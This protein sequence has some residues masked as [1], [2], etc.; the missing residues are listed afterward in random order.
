MENNRVETEYFSGTIPKAIADEIRFMR[1][2]ET[3]NQKLIKDY[4]D[5]EMEFMKEQIREIDKISIQYR[6]S[7]AKISDN[8][9]EAYKEYEPE[10]DKITSELYAHESKINDTI[11]RI[12]TKVTSVHAS[13]SQVFDKMKNIE[14]KLRGIETYQ[15]TRVIELIE[16]FS[17]MTDSDKEIFKMLLSK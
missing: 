11:Q 15:L 17:A 5:G 8:F 10:L 13:L 2:S 1:N 12:N 4:V 9:A 16:R 7:L 6:A 3:L 14:D